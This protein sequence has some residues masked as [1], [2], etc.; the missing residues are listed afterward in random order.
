[1]IEVLAEMTDHRHRSRH[2]HHHSVHILWNGVS[3]PLRNHWCF[4][5][6]DGRGRWSCE[7]DEAKRIRERTGMLDWL[8]LS[9]EPVCQN[10]IS[11]KTVLL[12]YET[13]G[14]VTIDRCSFLSEAEGQESDSGLHQTFSSN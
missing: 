13:G 11:L 1:M 6:L 14:N 10:G 5:R 9:V 8:E 7:D 3:A 2:V 4:R 12:D